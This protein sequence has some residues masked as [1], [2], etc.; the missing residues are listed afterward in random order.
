[1]QFGMAEILSIRDLINLWD[2]RAELA[3]DLQKLGVPVTTHQVH[4]WA[5]K[6]SIPSKYHGGVL[7]AGRARGYPVTAEL[8]IALHAPSED[9]A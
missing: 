4:K 3:L 2:R 5:E 1:M 6:S 8:I 7:T 9:A